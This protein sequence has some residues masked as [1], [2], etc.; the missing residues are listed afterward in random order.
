MKKW[1][2]LS[3]RERAAMIKVGVDNGI[4]DLDEIKKVYNKF[5]DGGDKKA[6]QKENKLHYKE[7]DIPYDEEPSNFT[8]NLYNRIMPV[9]AL[10]PEGLVIGGIKNYY[11]NSNNFVKNT[12]SDNQ[13]GTLDT[14]L[15]NN[16]KEYIKEGSGKQGYAEVMEP[17]ILEDTKDIYLGMPQRF[18]TYE[19]SKYK[20]K[21]ANNTTYYRNKFLEEAG[22]PLLLD[23]VNDIKTNTTVPEDYWMEYGR[24]YEITKNKNALVT[25]PGFGHATVGN[26]ID[27]SKG[28]YV[29]YY[30]KWDIGLGTPNSKHPLDYIYNPVNIYGRVY[31]DDYYGIDSSPKSGD[32]YGGYLP[33]ITIKA[34][35]S[36]NK[37]Y[38]K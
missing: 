26:S 30:D 16:V 8:R 3:M 20:P 4:I 32:Y 11:S 29:S 27:P 28:E 5:Q 17:Y 12:F 10:M 23:A 6:T 21:N 14:E 7:T 25:L 35:K 1:N 9:P 13:L 24:A 15:F 36:K 37:T 19:I 31:L 22:A 18:N 34:K 38:D 33:E 2:E